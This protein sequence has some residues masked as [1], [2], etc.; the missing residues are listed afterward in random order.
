METFKFWREK[1]YCRFTWLNSLGLW[2]KLVWVSTR[3]KRIKITDMVNKM[4]CSAKNDKNSVMLI[5]TSD[6]SCSSARAR[7]R[8][9][10]RGTAMLGGWRGSRHPKQL[11]SKMA[12]SSTLPLLLRPPHQA[13]RHPALSLILIS[14]VSIT[15]WCYTHTHT[16]THTLTHTHR[17]ICHRMAQMHN[18]AVMW[19]DRN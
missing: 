8:P 7:Q 11:V 14:R 2:P 1:N 10:I 19:R 17:E 13:P 18:T 4:K 16:H 5:Q 6:V 3:I 12:T 9:T 15:W